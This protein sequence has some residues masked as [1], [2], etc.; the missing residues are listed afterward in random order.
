VLGDRDLLQPVEVAQRIAPLGLE[1]R[2]M[3]LKG[4]GADRMFIAG[5]LL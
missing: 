3:R 2:L 4:I 1:P 5:P